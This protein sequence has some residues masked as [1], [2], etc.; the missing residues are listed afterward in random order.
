MERNPKDFNYIALM[1][2]AANP[3]ITEKGKAKGKVLLLRTF[4]TDRLPE[5]VLQV[6]IIY[7]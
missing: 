4:N 2:F 7:Y 3:A 6:K 1:Q 5:S